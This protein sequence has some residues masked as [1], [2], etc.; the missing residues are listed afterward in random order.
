ML[1]LHRRTVL[2]S[3]EIVAAIR[4]DQW[5]LPT[6]CAQWTLRDLLAHMIRENRGFAAAAGGETADRSAWSSPIGPDL[7][8]EYA[9]SAEAVLTAFAADGVLDRPVWL[10]LINDAVTFPGRQAVSFHLLDYLVHAWDAAMAS[11]QPFPADDEVVAAVYE[12]ALRE[13]PDG[14]RRVRVGA[15][16]APPTAMLSPTASMLDQV[17]AFLGRDPQWRRV[18]GFQPHERF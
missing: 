9:T 2:R 11:D 8:T 10:P 7:R 5:D 14:P 4:D 15:T 13:V 16:F 17:L 3:V 1:E 12:I 18:V 6:P